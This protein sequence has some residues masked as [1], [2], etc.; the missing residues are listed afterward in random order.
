M[1][2]LWISRPQR[3]RRRP[4]PDRFER[5]GAGWPAVASQSPPRCLPRATPS[6]AVGGDAMPQFRGD[7]LSLEQLFQELIRKRSSEGASE[8]DAASEL[9][10]ALN[11]AAITP[12]DT[13]DRQD[14]SIEVLGKCV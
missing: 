12:I 8:S 1:V 5:R 9:L 2:R 6:Q 3:D 10:D 11:H 7:L 13:N 4:R 14:N